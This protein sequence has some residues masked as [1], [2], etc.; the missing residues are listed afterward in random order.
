MPNLDVQLDSLSD[1]AAYRLVSS[2]VI[3]RPIAWVSTLDLAGVRNLAP[4]SFFN[5]A[6]ATPPIVHFSSAGYRTDGEPKDSLRNA[7]DSGEFVINIVD[8]EHL[9]AMNISSADFPTAED[10][11]HWAGLESEPSLLLRTPRVRGAVAALGCQVETIIEIGE[12][13]IVFGRVVEVHVA[14]R[15]WGS[16]RVNPVALDPLA[17]L[18]GSSYTR[19]GEIFDLRRPTWAELQKNPESVVQ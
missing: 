17:R 1:R 2:L 9:L 16:G 8:S 19:L 15:A 12:G 3:P 4:H 5:M 7:R 6:S 18:G 10:E 13:H 11:F 14:E